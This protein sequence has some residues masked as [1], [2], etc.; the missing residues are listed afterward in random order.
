MN[1]PLSATI[2]RQD[3]HF[4]VFVSKQSNGIIMLSSNQWGGTN[5]KQSKIKTTQNV[6]KY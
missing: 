4:A 1:L 6:D 3:E 2:S 5:G